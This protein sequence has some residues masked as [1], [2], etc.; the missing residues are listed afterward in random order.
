MSIAAAASSSSSSSGGGGS[1]GPCNNYASRAERFRHR[2]PSLSDSMIE[3]FLHSDCLIER[4]E[5][6]PNNGRCFMQIKQEQEEQE[7]QEE[8]DSRLRL[9]ALQ[10]HG[11]YEKDHDMPRSNSNVSANLDSIDRFNLSVSTGKL[12]RPPS[13]PECIPKQEISEDGDSTPIMGFGHGRGL[14]H[15]LACEREEMQLSPASD[16]ATAMHSPQ[17]PRKWMESETLGN[18]WNR[19]IEQTMSGPVWLQRMGRT[20]EAVPGQGATCAIVSGAAVGI[21][22]IPSAEAIR[23]KVGYWT[24]RGSGSGFG[25][26]DGGLVEAGV[27]VRVRIGD[28]VEVK[29][30]ARVRECLLYSQNPYF[31]NNAG[32]PWWSK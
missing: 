26:G 31:P 13:S 23:V 5:P 32:V 12:I 9:L 29:L 21:T 24:V 10:D 19:A 18:A 20:G 14:L 3:E 2:Y 1:D 17:S 27:S 15:H 7:E 11:D 25:F 4:V 6:G 22:D 30:R 8:H 28:A 16:R